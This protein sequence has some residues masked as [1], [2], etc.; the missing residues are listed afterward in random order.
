MIALLMMAATYAVPVSMDFGEYNPARET[1]MNAVSLKLG[2]SRLITQNVDA[3]HA[4]DVKVRFRSALGKRRLA[5]VNYSYDGKSLGRSVFQCSNAQID[6]C[7][8]AIVSGAER[9]SRLVRLR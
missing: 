4:L 7:S 5:V 1:F 2:K 9:A 6:S 8:T 3:F